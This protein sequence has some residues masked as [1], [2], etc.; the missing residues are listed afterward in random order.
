MKLQGVDW[1]HLLRAVLFLIVLPTI[2]AVSGCSAES[3]TPISHEPDNL[4][5]GEPPVSPGA[6]NTGNPSAGQGG[7]GNDST[8]TDNSA[9]DP[10]S[11]VVPVAVDSEM[12]SIQPFDPHWG[13]VGAFTN[14]VTCTDCHRAST[15]NDPNIQAVM[16]YPLSDTGADVSPGEGWSHSMMAHSFD[17]PYFQAVM[18]EEAHIFNSLAGLVEDTCLTCHAPMGRTH[19][20]LSDPTL[21]STE[22]CPLPDGCYRL[23]QAETEMHAREGVS[24]TLCHQIQDSNMGEDISFSGGYVIDA[25]AALIFGPFQN[26]HRGGA[27]VME[28]ISGYTPQFGNHMGRSTLCASCHTLFTPTIDVNTSQPTGKMFLEQGPFLEWQNSI[29]ATGNSTAKECQDC[30]MANPDS[31][32]QTRI[33]LRP[34]GSVNEV[35]PERQPF[36]QHTQSGGNT[37][38][39]QVLKTFR[40]TLGIEASTT[41]EGFDRQIARTRALLSTAADLSIDSVNKQNGRLDIDLTIH[42]YTGHKLPSAFPSRRLWIHLRVTSN[43]G[44]L[45]FESGAPSE[46]GRISTDD[47]NASERCLAI[48]KEEGFSNEG[49]VEPHRNIVTS[50]LQIPIYESVLA[51]TNGHVTHVLLHADSYLKDN[52]IPPQ[53]FL[54]A[55]QNPDTAVVGVALDTDFNYANATEGSGTDT[56]H[57]AIEVK[58]GPGAVKIEARLLYQTVRP[59]FVHGLHSGEL[60]GVKRFKTMHDQVPPTV[61]VLASTR[62][63]Y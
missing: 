27:R 7:L 60:P 8:Q 3:S 48:V 13:T 39:L 61:E 62:G 47:N 35:W 52:R 14:A 55:E 5:I 18:Q 38:M 42:N 41:E 45:L 4:A 43:S 53:G 21:L 6:G 33:S 30:H 11:P 19:A 1:R 23:A 24:C 37:Y 28:Q 32:Y 51:D 34:N 56:V 49:C 25:N 40:S 22:N 16:R 17:D 50:P 26:P 9:N 44:Q 36:F 63:S 10:S 2:T 54:A 12:E 20:H 57:Y 29:F 31:D 15:D 58:D 46:D 59:S